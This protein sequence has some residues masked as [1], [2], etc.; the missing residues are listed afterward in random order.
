M[1]IQIKERPKKTK[2]RNGCLTCKKK[3]LKCGEEKPACKNCV[4]KGIV[5]GGYS[6][7]FK[8]REFS[9]SVNVNPKRKKV[10]V[11]D[12]DHLQKALEEAT[13]SVTGKSTQEIAIANTLI[14]SGK[15]PEMATLIARTLHG[16]L[17]SPELKKME[18]TTN[19]NQEAI[20]NIVNTAM[21]KASVKDDSMLNSLADIASKVSPSPTDI[22]LSPLNIPSPTEMFLKNSAP[23]QNTQTQVVKKSPMLS[24]ASPL[25]IFKEATSLTQNAPSPSISLPRSPSTLYNFLSNGNSNPQGINSLVDV[26]TNFSQ[27]EDD[28]PQFDHNSPVIRSHHENLNDQEKS[29]GFNRTISALSPG[30]SNLMNILNNEEM[31]DDRLNNSISNIKD[32]DIKPAVSISPANSLPLAIQSNYSI[33]T[34][35]YQ[36]SN[37][38][39]QTLRLFDQYTCGIMSIKNGPHENPW[40]TFLLPMSQDHPVMRNALLA[41]TCFHVA[42]GDLELRKRGVGY[43]KDAIL[44]LV[45]GLSGNSSPAILDSTPM[46]SGPSMERNNSGSTLSLISVDSVNSQTERLP[47]DVALATC[48]ALAVGE[49]WD[50]NV[51]TGIAHLKGAKS[52]IIQVLNQ[53]GSR[54]RKKRKR[55]RS[56]VDSI[57]ELEDEN[58]SRRKIPK[59]LQFLVNAWMYFDV[60]ARM[61]CDGEE[62]ENIV[63]YEDEHII[64]EDSDESPSTNKKR[65]FSSECDS[66]AVI[67]KFRSFNLSGGDV[68]DPLLG[69]AQTLFP[70]MGE[71]ASLV[72]KVRAL[73]RPQM[74]P[75]SNPITYPKT[76]L[77]YITLAGELKRKLEQ[78]SLPRITKLEIE[79]DT[80]DLSSAFATAEA[81][82]YATLLYLH[83][84]ITEIPSPSS[85][86]LAENVM[87]LLASVPASSRTIVTHM[88][89]LL[90]ASCEAKEGDERSWCK[91]RWKVLEDKMWLGTIERAYQ[92]V[93]EVWARKDLMRRTAESNINLGNKEMEK[94]RFDKVKRRI[95]VSINGDDGELESDEDNRIMGWTHWT[96]IMKEWGWEV[97]L[98]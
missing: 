76:P 66:T 37:T 70:I 17:E 21:T 19:V 23:S 18:G 79:D 54:K 96:T 77:K 27:N 33:P 60:L 55:R 44:G 15:N 22:P 40:R 58:L 7:N 93:K 72:S 65:S 36:L 26:L 97:L 4:S 28:F 29:P 88:F 14:A 75:P 34:D 95:S 6:K 3:R 42:R 31:A 91:E 68:L 16:I 9:D 11:E 39:L 43:M 89:P 59:E 35:S 78:W 38:H 53:L 86:S 50:R 61:T 12:K 24:V 57:S 52:M 87:M 2:S 83:Q 84:A 10:V 47:P 80:C 25:N 73:Y 82:R 98:A 49:A 1:N 8:W 74:S 63:E 67:N 41:M 90:V 51:S 64:K 46:S 85:H 81:Y 94:V 62:G 20:V 5:C 92:V 30:L 71:V 69:V 45:E 13:L 32:E 48:L 56:S